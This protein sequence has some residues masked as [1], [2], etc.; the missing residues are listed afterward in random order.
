[1]LGACFAGDFYAG[2][3]SRHR[4]RRHSFWQHKHIIA[5]G[6]RNYWRCQRWTTWIPRRSRQ[7]IRTDLSSLRLRPILM[8]RSQCVAAQ[9]MKEGHGLVACRY[10]FKV[11]CSA[12]RIP[13]RRDGFEWR[14]RL[15]VF[16]CD[17]NQPFSQSAILAQS[18]LSIRST[19]KDP[20]ST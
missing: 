16:P 15:S 12:C 7:Q 11:S 17:V 8:Q 18:S 13:M 3:G 19:C 6:K 20:R 1:M 4:R 5:G 10:T 14:S 9:R 2:D